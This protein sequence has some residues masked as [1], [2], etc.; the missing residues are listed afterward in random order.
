MK[1]LESVGEVR[2]RAAR[3]RVTVPALVVVGRPGDDVQ[4]ARRR[5]GVDDRLRDYAGSGRGRVQEALKTVW[6]DA[7]EAIE[8]RD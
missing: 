1:D 3:R 8:E 7:E 5:G 4:P 2:A 6:I